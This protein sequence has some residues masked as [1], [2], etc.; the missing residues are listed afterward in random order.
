MSEK[1]YYHGRHGNFPY[2]GDAIYITADPHYARRYA[3]NDEL[4]TYSLKFPSDKIFSIKNKRHVD[5][6]RTVVDSRSVNALLRDSGSGEADWAAISYISTDDYESIE[7]VLK[8]LK[9]KALAVQE[10]TGIE[11]LLVFTEDDLTFKGRVTYPAEVNARLIQKK[12][13]NTGKKEWALVSKKTPSKILKWFGTAKPS[14]KAVLKEERRVQF[15][16]TQSAAPQSAIKKIT[17]KYQIVAS[18]LPRLLTMF[19]SAFNLYDKLLEPSAAEARKRKTTATIKAWNSVFRRNDQIIWALRILRDWEIYHL[20]RA[21]SGPVSQEHQTLLQKVSTNARKYNS[22]LNLFTSFQHLLD[23]ARIHQFKSM[24]DYRFPIDASP[25]DIHSKLASLEKLEHEKMD[26]ESRLL[27]PDPAESDFLKL[28]GGWKWVLIDRDTCKREGAA[29]NHCGNANP[30]EGDQILSLR[31]LV[32]K[33]TLEKPHLTFIINKGILGEMKGFANNKPSEKYHKYII[34]LLKD[35]RI[36]SIY[37]GG[38]APQNNF[39]LSDLSKDVQ[40][41]LLK[42][43]PTLDLKHLIKTDPES[44]VNAWGWKVTPDKEYVIIYPYKNIEEFLRLN[45]FRSL[46]DDDD[47]IWIDSVGKEDKESLIEKLAKKHPEQFHKLFSN[48]VKKSPEL[49]EQYEDFDTKDEINFG[50]TNF[51]T[52]APD[53]LQQMLKDGELD[54][55]FDDAL[56]SAVRDGWTSG[57]RSSWF[58]AYRSH[59]KEMESDTGC[60][61]IWKDPNKW[62]DSEVYVAFPLLQAA[63][64]FLETEGDV[65]GGS[66]PEF[67]W[68]GN[69]DY[70]EKA[71]LDQLVEHHLHWNKLL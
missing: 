38:Y 71:A 20:I 19:N 3:K 17:A 34:P 40:D 8:F 44:V 46:D 59:L 13:L 62:W 43:K 63:E 23:T 22:L 36:I 48:L 12:N 66:F 37:G 57:A 58:E 7:D 42:E 61:L 49:F 33:G 27:S 1:I 64:Y 32:K 14:E 30:K 47:L 15:F 67:T 41:S 31:E 53:I 29:M 25:E 56:D 50:L 45:K 6:L 55:G 16:K 24:L 9:F 68:S 4:Y 5:L 60:T 70:D 11:S 28:P 52:E 26:E 54:E 39:S 10:R 65:E 18:R 21:R 51:K 35:P 2:S 69:Y